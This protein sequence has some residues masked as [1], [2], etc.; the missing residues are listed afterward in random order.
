MQSHFQD[1]HSL[2]ID[3]SKAALYLF[4]SEM[5]QKHSEMHMDTLMTTEILTDCVIHSGSRYVHVPCC[6]LKL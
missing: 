5:F 2:S 6:S 3:P 4:S 1:T